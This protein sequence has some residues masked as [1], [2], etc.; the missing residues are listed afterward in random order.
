MS[1]SGKLS[2]NELATPTVSSTS[3]LVLKANG[4]NYMTLSASGNKIEF[5]KAIDANDFDLTEVDIKSGSI[6]GVTIN[7]SSIGATTANTGAFTTLSA[8]TSVNFNNKIDNDDINTSAAIAF[9]KLA[10]LNDGQI[11]IGS[12]G[13]VAT[14][15]A[16][17]GDI[18][19]T[20]AG[21]TTIGSE[22]VTNAKIEDST[23]TRDKILNG[24]LQNADLNASAGIEFS[25]LEGLTSG[26]ILLG[27]G[28]NIPTDTAISGDI[29]ITNAG[30][31][32]I[33]T[34]AIVNADVNTNADISGRKLADDTIPAKKLQTQA[35]PYEIQNEG[36]FSA[37]KVLSAAQ[38]CG[39]MFRGEPNA[40]RTITTTSAADLVTH[41]VDASA[42]LGF[43]YIV[44]NEA[45]GGGSKT[46]NM[47]AGTGCTIIG[48]S[49][50]PKEKIRHYMVHIKNVG[51]GTEAYD[52]ISITD[53]FPFT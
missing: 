52:L 5:H 25:K 19:I 18:T 36:S 17:S 3:D 2:L 11:L 50:I 26:R 45:T 42:N 34:G 35:V 32:S 1:V 10:S 8:S 47:V 39:G 13:N 29:G 51:S 31:V 7:N 43:T 15:S 27:N 41:L 23:I 53:D 22:K 40:D 33:S 20:N 12:A 24:T 44:R 16:I 28:S 49:T 6:E 4:Q 14:A 48:G 46:L 38:L 9:S 37:D 21:V 30:V